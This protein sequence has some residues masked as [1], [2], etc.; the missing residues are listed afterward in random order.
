MSRPTGSNADEWELFLIEH[1]TPFAAV[2][3]AEAIEACEE[4]YRQALATIIVNGERNSD[5]TVKHLVDYA[6][7]QLEGGEK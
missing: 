5:T 4:R 6:R 3:I 1:P 7:E 2:Q